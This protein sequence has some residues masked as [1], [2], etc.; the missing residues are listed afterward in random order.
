MK[1]LAHTSLVLWVAPV[2]TPWL[3]TAFFV[4]PSFLSSR[5]MGPVWL[6]VLGTGAVSPVVAGVCWLTH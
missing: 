6:A 4:Y 2:A 5:T 3:W 1:G